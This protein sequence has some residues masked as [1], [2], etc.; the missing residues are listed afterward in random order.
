MEIELDYKPHPKQKQIHR[1]LKPWFSGKEIMVVAGRRFGKTVCSVNEIGARAIEIPYTRVWYVTNTKEQAYDI[2]WPMMTEGWSDKNGKIHPPFLPNECVEKKRM[3]KHWI[4]LYNGSW[5]QFKGIQD[6]LFILGAGLGFVVLDEFPAIPWS[7][8]YDTIRPMLADKNGDALFI[9]TVPDPWVHNITPEFL[10]KYEDMLLNPTKNRKAFNFSSF[11]NPHISHKKIES[12]VAD[13][14][15][16]GR[17]GDAQRLYYGKYSRGA[18]KLWPMFDY[19]SHTVEPIKIPN[20]WIR[21]MALDPHP[22][23]PY[24]AVWAAI[25]PDNHYWFYREVEFKDLDGRPLTV[26]ET[27]YEI[28]E[29]ENT[30][31]EKVK[32]RLID[33]TYAKIQ[34]NILN[35]KT[36]KDLLR[37]YGLH[38]VEADRNF[39]LFYNKFGDMLVEEPTPTVHIFRPCINCI[40]QIN[41][42][43]WDTYASGRARAERGPKDRPKKTDDDYRDCMKY[44]INANIHHVDMKQHQTWR[45]NLRQKWARRQFM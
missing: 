44:I 43:V 9:G 3:D 21:V 13:L 11:D 23:K 8:W 32:R 22:Q 33:P 29:I 28:L 18:G 27:A 40:R 16:R 14:Q 41:N 45:E 35:Q 38:F 34:Q 19:E 15:K 6:E 30:A 39:D 2:A 7:A 37:D 42:A 25:A 31:K 17:E 10:E 5:I 4:K 20:N 1:A 26:Q 12:D 24:V 36:I